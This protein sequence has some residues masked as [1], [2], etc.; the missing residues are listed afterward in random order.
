[1]CKYCGGT[2]CSDHRLPEKHSCKG[3]SEA[4]LTK[5]EQADREETPDQA[6]GPPPVEIRYEVRTHQPRR[7][8]GFFYSL[9]HRASI[10][11]LLLIFLVFIGQLVA[12]AVLGRTY[13]ITGNH[14]TFLYYLTPSQATVLTMPWTLVTHIFLHD[15]SYPMVFL[16]LPVN[17]LVLLSFGPL[18]ET[19]IGRRRFLLTFFGSGIIA[20]AAQILVLP[21]DVVVL[22]ASGA[23]LGV[24]GTLTVLVPR[25]P[26]LFFFIP[27]PLWV[28]SLSFG[29][30]SVILAL[31]AVGGTIGHT[32]HLTG[33]IV[34]LIYGYRLLREKR[35]EY[36]YT[37]RFSNPWA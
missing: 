31:L 16:H 7:R 33:L 19:I 11:I 21:P 12:Q 4:R 17:A 6:S 30:L 29:A 2:F 20:G 18:L 3:F 5:R 10:A 26:V 34:G 37:L 27:M 23:I 22:G 36:R 25:L 9:F 15:V 8:T 32:A 35:R 14:S 24:L 1:M 13:Y 28:A